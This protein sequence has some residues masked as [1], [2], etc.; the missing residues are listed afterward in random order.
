MKKVT[1]FIAFILL[2]S[3]FSFTANAQTLTTTSSGQISTSAS[4]L[5]NQVKLFQEQKKEALT[6]AREEARTLMEAKR[7]EFKVRLQTIKDEKKAALV[8]RIDAKLNSVNKK[9]TERFT[10]VVK[11]LQEFLDKI[12]KDKTEQKQLA[13]IELAQDA[14]NLAQI[15]VEDQAAKV[16]AIEIVSETTLKANTGKTTSQLRKDLTAVHKLVVDAKQALVNLRKNDLT[17]KKEATGSAEL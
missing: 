13:E 7:E 1:S 17:I 12:S 3:F 8:E 11:K 15:A 2:F 9:H 4:K 10:E 14:I 5:Q 16:Y 6:K